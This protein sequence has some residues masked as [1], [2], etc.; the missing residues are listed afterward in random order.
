MPTPADPTAPELDTCGCAPSADAPTPVSVENAPGLPALAW[1]VGTHGRFL[2]GQKLRLAAHP[3]LRALSTREPSDPAI[4]L[5]DAWSCVLDVLTFHQERFAQ[6]NYLRS[7]TERRSVLE[8]ARAIGYELRPGV[9]ASVALAFTVESVPGAPATV[10]LDPGLKVQSVPGQDERPQTFETV[11]TLEA[12]PGWNTLRPRLS[13]SSLPL[14]LGD[15]EV[16][17]EGTATGLQ[18][19]DALLFLGEERKGFAGSERWDF[20]R[21]AALELFPLSPLAG[22]GAGRTRVTLDRPLGHTAPTIHPSAQGTEI[23]ALRQRANVFGYNATD[24]N[25]LPTLTQNLYRTAA[26]NPP[27]TTPAD[28]PKFQVFT[29]TSPHTLDLDQVYPKI[30][31]AG[32]WLVLSS[33]DYQ[34]VYPIASAVEAARAEFGLSAKTTRLTLGDGENH[35]TFDSALR[36]VVVYAQSERLA[37]A[38]RPLTTTVEGNDLVLDTDASDLPAGRLLALTGTDA[39]TGLAASEIVELR[40]A[41]LTADGL[42]SLALSAPLARAYVRDSLY[43]NA[44][45]AR[46]T[47]GETKRAELLGSGDGSRAFQSFPLKQSPLTHV[48]SPLASG[49]AAPALEIRVGGVLWHEVPS[50]LDVG[51]AER[52]YTLRLADDGTTT[53]RFG[54][55]RTGARL[56]TGVNNVVAT[57]RS[58]LGLEGQVA[59]RSLTTLLTR[60]LGAKAVTNPLAAAGAADPE[61]LADARDNAPLT[62]LTLDRIVSVRDHEDFARAYAGVGKARADLVWDGERRLIHLTV[63]AVDGT[64]LDPLGETY[65]NLR[66]ALDGAR[67]AARPVQLAPHLPLGFGL[68]ARVA[69]A[70]EL[71][72]DEVLAAIHAALANAFGFDARSFGE[73]VAASQLMTVIQNVPGVVAVDLDTLGYVSDDGTYAPQN[74]LTAPNLPARLAHRDAQEVLRGAELLLVSPD[75]VTLSELVAAG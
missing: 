66:A 52:V 70:P 25:T 17:L 67:H 31:A 11:E 19:G 39:A 63:A 20:R 61:Q 47:H 23:Y 22:A 72:R 53:V 42:T 33:P 71:L 49:G 54:D 15:T 45:V 27:V 35:A 40:A 59:A 26:G 75:H 7:A 44:N 74:A 32:G 55:G 30:I 5:L 69:T 37:F 51:P 60:P 29:A 6:E 65:R 48:S 62:V 50:F 8:L 10:R 21:V 73:G 38:S 12:R 1:R 13:E 68:E 34:E 57:Y 16:W 46:A 43:L 58:G 18:P 36:E 41:T 4:A 28:W 64:A 3:A 56:P 24:W 2:A 14:A 9:A